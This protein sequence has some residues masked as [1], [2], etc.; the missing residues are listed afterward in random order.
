MV[1]STV[2][3]SFNHNKFK[4]TISSIPKKQKGQRKFEIRFKNRDNV[5]L[6]QKKKTVTLS[7]RLY[8]GVGGGTGTGA[9]GA[10]EVDIRSCV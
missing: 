2:K 4:Q 1:Q 3:N 6:E 10:T 9:T 7:G 8:D 5:N